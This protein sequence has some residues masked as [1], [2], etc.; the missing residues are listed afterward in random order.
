MSRP[1][2]SGQASR[3]LLAF[4]FLA[5]AALSASAKELKLEAKLIWG[6]NDEKSPNPSHKPIDAVT[7][8]KLRKV[9]K[10]K[11]Y[12]VVTNQVKVVPS[13]GSNRF[14]L[15]KQC[16]IEVTELEGPR[17]EVKLIGEGKEVNKTIK[18]LQKGESIT[19]GKDDKNDNAWFVII[20]ELDEK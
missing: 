19:Y 10:W 20:T 4:F 7:A 12:F 16:S 13:R 5:F 1:F 6:T 15:S 17:V 9:F 3:W 11:N 18:P 8:E 2:L 14:D